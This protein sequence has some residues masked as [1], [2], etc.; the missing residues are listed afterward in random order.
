[1]ELFLIFSIIAFLAIVGNA[2]VLL[3][4]ARKPELSASVRAQPYR[5][6]DD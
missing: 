2:L 1:M 4:T 5:N 6:D 3:R